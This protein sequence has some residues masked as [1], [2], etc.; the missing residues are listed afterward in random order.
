[1]TK[2]IGRL[3]QVGIAK[4]TTRGT[5]PSTADF[6]IPFSDVSFDEKWENALDEQSIGV[7]EDSKGQSRTKSWAEGK[8]TAPI[9][10]QSFPLVIYGALGSYTKS[11]NSDVSGNV[12]DHTFTVSQ[13]AQ[14]QSLAFYIDDP[15]A[16]ADYKYANGM[17]DSLEINYELKK[18]LDF[19]LNLMT[20]SG[21]SASLTPSSTAQNRF[22]PQH[23]TFKVAASYATLSTG[24][25]VSLK[26]MKL[27]IT[28]NVESDDVLGSTSPADFLNKQ[29]IIEGTIEALWQNES[30]FKTAALAGTAKALRLDL[31]NTDV[32]IGTAA[33]PR[34]RIDL[35]KVVF[36][37][38]TRPLVLNDLVKQT[39][40]FKAHYSTTDSLMV[41][42]LATNLKTTY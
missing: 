19:S 29:F 2:G 9:E 12:I 8:L 18:F 21:A 10:D 36:T 34:L 25:A 26:S 42:V 7:I 20:V 3:L 11:T 24:T 5:A 6:Y 38:L 4:E 27:K 28:K 32:T 39:L 41:S 30:D 40:S 22:L 33:N 16:G 31:I 14:H 15:L 35:A 13:S 23:L 1:M 17:V 37:E